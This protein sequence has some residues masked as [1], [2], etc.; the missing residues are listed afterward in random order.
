LWPRLGPS[1]ARR[2]IRD[3]PQRVFIRIGA[4]NRAGEQLA[5]EIRSRI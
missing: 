2:Q 5:A 1:L 4:L 3:V